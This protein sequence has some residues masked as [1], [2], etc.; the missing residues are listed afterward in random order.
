[1][2]LRRL[3]L[4]FV[5]ISKAQPAGFFLQMSDPQFGMYSENRDLGLRVVIW[6]DTGI[7]HR[8]YGLGSI[9]HEVSVK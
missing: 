6:S 5:L 2:K 3:F 8:Y 4:I 1:M 9:P 7:D